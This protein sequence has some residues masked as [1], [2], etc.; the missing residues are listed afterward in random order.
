MTLELIEEIDKTL[1]LQESVIREM[2]KA[3]E[4]IDAGIEAGKPEREARRKRQDLDRR[5]REA[6]V[7]RL[8]SAADRAAG[9]S[10]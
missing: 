3:A 1:R 10:E 2:R 9:P 4:K 6:S 8:I 5:R 7:A